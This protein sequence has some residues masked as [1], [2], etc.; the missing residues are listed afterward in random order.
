MGAVVFL[1][2]FDH[3]QPAQG[4]FIH[5]PLQTN[6]FRRKTKFLSV[7]QLDIGRG[8]GP[9]H[10]V[11]LTQVQ[12]QGLFANHVLPSGGRKFREFAVQIVRAT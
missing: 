4:A 7:H 3:V 12:A 10:S 9:D 1:A 11:G 6:I 2:L 5:E 8:A